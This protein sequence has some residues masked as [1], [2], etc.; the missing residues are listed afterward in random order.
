VASDPGAQR[1]QVEIVRTPTGEGDAFAR[2]RVSHTE[3]STAPREHVIYDSARDGRDNRVDHVDQFVG[4]KPPVGVGVVL[5]VITI[6]VCGTD[7]DESTRSPR[8]RPGLES[9]NSDPGPACNGSFRIDGHCR[10]QVSDQSAH[11]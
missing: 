6:R 2:R 7:R 5:T 10:R 3:R 4:I 1:L 8:E 11:W 9:M